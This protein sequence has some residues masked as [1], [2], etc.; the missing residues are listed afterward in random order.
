M[1]REQKILK[2]ISKDGLGIEIG[3]S[4]RPVAPKKQGYRV[5]IIDHA[6]QEQL[7]EKYKTHNINL[8]AI[9][10][11][12]YV[13][14]G[15]RYEELT[16]KQHFYDW[17]IA[18]HVIE[19]APDLIGFLNSCDAILKAGGVLSLVI[20]D[21][22]Y[23]FDHFRPL[24]GLSKIIDSNLL[25]QHIHTPGTVAEYYLNVV[26]RDGAIAWHPANKGT[27]QFVHSL[28]DAASGIERVSERGEYIDVHA[29]C[30]TPHSLRL[31]ME[32]LYALNLIQLREVDFFPTAGCEFFMTL[33]RE[34]AGSQMSRMDL[35]QAVELEL[36]KAVLPDQTPAGS[37]HRS[38]PPL[39][40]QKKASPQV[41]PLQ[42]VGRLY[43][44]IKSRLS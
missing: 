18:S 2:H 40:P 34:G 39:Q 20:P 17:I 26:S 41:K 35:L 36:A 11:V 21:K 31:L 5:E 14:R 16:G 29:W 15:E 22:R 24:T 25:K 44:K 32:D 13:W 3:P 12:D 10:E 7:R 9:E 38:A 8:D 30:F 1:N 19:H 43:S 33:S 4:H 37:S 28:Q 23:C 6:S 27:Y 42:T